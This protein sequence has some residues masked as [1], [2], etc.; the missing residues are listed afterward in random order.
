MDRKALKI[1]EAGE[2]ENSGLLKTHNLL[3]N[4]DARNAKNAAI[5]ADWSVSG[6]QYSHVRIEIFLI[7]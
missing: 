2:S 7:F 4:R 5:A 3:K 1:L 6:T